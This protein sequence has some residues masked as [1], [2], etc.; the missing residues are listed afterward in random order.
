M[1]KSMEYSADTPLPAT[2]GWLPDVNVW[3]ALCSDR[4]E[5][6]RAAS[7]WLADVREALYFC[8]MTQMALLR[9]LTNAKVMGEDLRSPPQAIEVYRTLLSD[10]RFQ[11]AQEPLAV[12]GLWLSLMTVPVANGTAWTDAWLAAFSL[13]HGSRLVSFDSG[14]RRWAMLDPEVLSS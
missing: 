7:D 12:E 8:R 5:F 4:H 3:L 11:F 13:A 6:H 14:M 10:E 2:S 1:P 9:L